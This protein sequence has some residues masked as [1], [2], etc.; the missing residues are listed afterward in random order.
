MELFGLSVEQVNQLLVAIVT[1]LA[2]IDNI[3]TRMAHKNAKQAKTMIE[4]TQSVVQELTN[5][6]LTKAVKEAVA[7]VTEKGDA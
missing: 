2:I 7:E 3:T 1:I 6:K 5:G 4:D